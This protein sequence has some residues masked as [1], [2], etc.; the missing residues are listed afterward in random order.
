M[1]SYHLLHTLADVQADDTKAIDAVLKAD[2]KRLDLLEEAK[3]LEASGTNTDR[4]KE[5]SV[6]AC[7]LK[8]CSYSFV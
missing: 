7:S 3:K 8:C 1:L 6:L 2:K 4:L 5:V